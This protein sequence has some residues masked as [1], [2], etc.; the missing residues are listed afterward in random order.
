MPNFAANLVITKCW[1][2]QNHRAATDREKVTEP[3][4]EEK[5]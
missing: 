1:K 5:S 2:Q 4:S 3:V